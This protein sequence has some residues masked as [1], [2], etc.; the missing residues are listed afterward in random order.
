MNLLPLVDFLFA[1][2]Q[3]NHCIELLHSNELFL[4]SAMFCS[5]SVEN[6]RMKY[7]SVKELERNISFRE[8]MIFDM[9]LKNFKNY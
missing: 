4:G 2:E 1:N 5:I 3:V 7:T 6:E 8:M 9:L